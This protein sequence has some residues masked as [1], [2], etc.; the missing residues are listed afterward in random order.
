MKKIAKI[1]LTALVFILLSGT[2]VLAGT[3]STGYKTI[4]GKLNGYGFSGY[5]TKTYT[6]NSGVLYSS[7]VG[8]AYV[9][10]VRMDGIYDG[11]WVRDVNDY[12]TRTLPSTSGQTSGSSIRLKFS[13]DW[14]TSVDVLV[15]GSWQS[16]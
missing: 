9:V 1:F 8:G 16:N 13:N 6:G 15:S 12:Q 14:N 4:V 10:D 2:A 7:L 3:S 11:A 5:Q